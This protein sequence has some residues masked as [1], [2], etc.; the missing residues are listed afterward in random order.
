[1]ISSIQVSITKR[2]KCTGFKGIVFC[3][4]GKGILSFSKI[5]TGRDGKN[6]Q[7]VE[8]TCSKCLK[9]YFKSSIEEIIKYLQDHQKMDC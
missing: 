5:Y 3:E 4:C 1:M 8:G 6:F 9:I 2:E 7:G